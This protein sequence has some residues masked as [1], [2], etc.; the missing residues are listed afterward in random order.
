MSAR[1][2]D[3]DAQCIVTPTHMD[4][5]AGSPAAR[6]FR[7][8]G[9][10]NL[11][12]Q[13]HDMPSSGFGANERNHMISETREAPPGM[14]F[15]P[16]GSLN[17]PLSMRGTGTPCATDEGTRSLPSL[18]EGRLEDHPGNR[19]DFARSLPSLPLS[20][21]G[22]NPSHLERF[23]TI[24]VPVGFNGQNLMADWVQ[25]LKTKGQNHSMTSSGSL[26]N[27]A[28]DITVPKSRQSNTSPRSFSGTRSL[29]LGDLGISHMLAAPSMS[30]ELLSGNPSTVDLVRANRYGM[31]L[32]SSNEKN[33]PHQKSETSANAGSGSQSQAF[34][35]KRD[36]SSIY[37]R[38]SSPFS[39]GA[40]TNP[41]SPKVH[42]VNILKSTLG[43]KDNLL[44]ESAIVENNPDQRI[45]F[46]QS[47][48][49]E[50]FDSAS[51]EAYRVRAVSSEASELGSPRKVSIGWMSGG[52]R[53]G[54]GYTMVSGA[55]E[56]SE[57]PRL[58]DTSNENQTSNEK[59]QEVPAVDRN[60]ETKDCQLAKHSNNTLK[61]AE[62]STVQHG[63]SMTAD[64]PDCQALSGADTL[65]KRNTVAD[66]TRE[67]TV[68]A[69]LWARLR[70]RSSRDHDHALTTNEPSPQVIPP[71]D[72]GD[73]P[74]NAGITG[75]MTDTLV[76]RWSRM[77]RNPSIQPRPRKD[78]EDTH[79]GRKTWVLGASR[80]DKGQD[81][82]ISIEQPGSLQPE[83][84]RVTAQD[85]KNASKVHN[86]P[87]SAPRS[88]RWGFMFFRHR[89]SR[90]IS[91]AH[92]KG[93]SQ[94]SSGQYQ[95]CT[96]NSLDRA[97]STRSNRA[98]DLASMYQECI[99]MPGSFEGSQWASRLSRVL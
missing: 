61:P 16:P 71:S 72:Q 88:N 95:D 80:P 98:E 60:E 5:F 32:S 85:D 47:K 49:V 38:P 8:L 55:E 39:A 52:R 90:R 12:E 63:S 70:N 4:R 94:A 22:S 20:Q 99:E 11:I 76:N 67:T 2:Y 36:A 66:I 7:R 84:C 19:P 81:T 13:S 23:P 73:V 17:L 82:S 58:K 51:A 89:Q 48:F 45:D 15:T 34:P 3:S 79:H 54:Y 31:L 9:L 14:C 69:S 75:I 37:S 41:Q 93:P 6:G 27:Q 74:P 92:P 83:E 57:H 30:S 65:S 62:T 35:H 24:E 97:D 86:S 42:A 68:S 64:E 46:L 28:A 59:M 91:T 29:H 50:R 40:P 53:V 21:G 87:P 10:G 77:S 78:R 96:S 33:R 26:T 25:F 44:G 43:S 1:G 56:G 18:G